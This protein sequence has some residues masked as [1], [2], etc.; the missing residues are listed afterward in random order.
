MKIYKIVVSLIVFAICLLL[1]NVQVHAQAIDATQK[2]LSHTFLDGLRWGFISVLQPCLYAMF[3]VTVSFFLKRSESKSQGVRNALL[4]SI[5]IIAIFVFFAFVITLIFGRSTLY[6][7]STSATFNIF[8]F[9]LFLIFGISFLGAFE[10]T[11]PSSWTNKADAKAN[12]KSFSG[13]FFMALTLVLVSFSCTAPFI[14][15]LLV[16]VTK[17]QERAGPIIGFLGFSSAIALPFAFFALFP[18]WLNKIAKSGGWLN[19]LKVSFGFIEIAMALKF[20]SNADLAYHWHLLDRDIYL[21]LWIIIFGLMGFY[22][23]GKIKFSHDDH[24]PLNDYGHP[25]VSVPRLLFAIAALSFTVYMVPGLWG[26]PLN[27]ISG[28]LPENK[29]Q[30]FN[31][32]KLIKNARLNADGNDSSKNAAIAIKPKKYTDILSSE[33]PGVQTFFDFDEA[34][35]AARTMNKPI[36]IDFTGHSCA[37]CRKMEAEVLSKPE[38]SAVLHNDFVVA[39]LYVD[40][41]RALPDSEQYV[42]KFDQSQIDNVG[43]R[44]LDFEATI[45][46]SNAQPLYIL[47]DETGKII[48][49]AGGYDPDVQRFLT[50]LQNAKAENKKRFP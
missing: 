23:L 38:V 41:K 31:L 27:G 4:Y 12:M 2:T 11:L 40:E 49:N 37:N 26:A 17:Q 47:A 43:A 29:T 45:A 35:A 28:W 8:V 10:I 46:N 9:V 30:D 19:T 48:Q 33:I 50:M 36:M 20:L 18:G 24:L 39:S 6:N 22:L 14:G 32:E 44:N 16:D 3:P 34:V 25:Y 13:I 21:S 5:S 7:I 42:S 1:C 15:N